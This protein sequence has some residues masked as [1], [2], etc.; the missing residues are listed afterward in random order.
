LF[1]GR[2]GRGQKPPPQFGQTLSRTFSTQER[3]KVHSNV[4]IIA[5]VE[6]G[7]SAALQFSQAGLSSS[8]AV[9]CQVA[10]VSFGRACVACVTAAPA[11]RA[12]ATIAASTISAS[13]APAL[14]ALPLWISMQNGH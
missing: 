7:G 13:V 2:T 9:F 3:Q 10:L 14:R 1:F 6:F 12:A 5:S 4:Q 11:R 8:I